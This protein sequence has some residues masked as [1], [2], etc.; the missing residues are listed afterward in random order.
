MHSTTRSQLITELH[1]QITTAAAARGEAQQALNVARSE[2]DRECAQAT[3]ADRAA[4]TQA[5]RVIR[6]PQCTQKLARQ[7]MELAVST[8]RGV[9]ETAQ[10]WTRQV[11]QAQRA[12]DRAQA[13]LSQLRRDL[14]DQDRIIEGADLTGTAEDV[15][16]R[17]QA[18]GWHL[19]VE[20][21]QSIDD[22]PAHEWI[23][24]TECQAPGECLELHAAVWPK[25]TA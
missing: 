14:D 10:W 6:D 19:R 15:A 12:A 5:L 16:A 23:E 8:H 1:E 22:I 2:Y 21:E 18:Q 4:F 20:T 24:A 17:A 25:T 7:Q 3:A 11:D 9:D 13:T